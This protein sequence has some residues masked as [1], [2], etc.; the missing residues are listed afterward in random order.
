M[1]VDGH[2]D[3]LGLNTVNAVKQLG[4]RISDAILRS[5]E[6]GPRIVEKVSAQIPG[7]LPEFYAV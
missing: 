7:R 4:T 5:L 2:N 3:P 1:A 6:N